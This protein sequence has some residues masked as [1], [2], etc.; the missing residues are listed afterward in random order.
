[1]KPTPFLLFRSVYRHLA[2][3]FYTFVGRSYSERRSDDKV[4]DCRFLF[5]DGPFHHLGRYWPAW[6]FLS[7]FRHLISTLQKHGWQVCVCKSEKGGFSLIK[8]AFIPDMCFSVGVG[9]GVSSH[10]NEGLGL[11]VAREK[12][13]TEKVQVY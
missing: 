5:V 6:P 1:M 11:K 4:S 3:I 2:C 9:V 10:F 8:S 7:P 13:S 12:N